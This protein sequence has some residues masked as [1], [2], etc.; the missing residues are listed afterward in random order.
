MPDPHN[1]P[2]DWPE[3]AL[4]TLYRASV[5]FGTQEQQLI[6]TRYTGFLVLNGWLSN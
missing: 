1:N 4:A 3:A 5:S 6:W 2:D